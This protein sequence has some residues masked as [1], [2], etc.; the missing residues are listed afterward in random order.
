MSNFLKNLEASGFAKKNNIFS[1]PEIDDLENITHKI[2]S[3]KTIDE[4]IVQSNIINEGVNYYDNTHNTLTFFNTISR[5]FLGVDKKLDILF[6]KLL[7]NEDIK[8]YLIKILGGNYKINTCVLRSGDENSNYLG[9]HTDNNYQFTFSV[10]CNKV[11]SSDYTTLFLP[12]SHKFAYSFKNSIEK[13]NPNFF[14]LFLK[15][16]FGEVGDIVSFFNKT[17]HGVQKNEYQKKKSI[18]MLLAFHKDSD[19]NAK[20]LI[21]PQKTLYK[22]KFENVF[23][24]DVLK[25]FEK[26]E[27]S[28]N[29][30]LDNRENLIDKINKKNSLNI[31]LKFYCYLLRLI[32]LILSI[33]VSTYRLLKN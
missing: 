3:K 20:S 9:L 14:K 24:Y 17:M 8:N 32:K 28:R 29:Y 15:P 13:I 30:L 21:L 23:S 10:F 2:I 5:N 1:R 26:K 31:K 22:E 12:G 27:S 33:L 7:S 16:S 25:L 11:N 18:V 4:K 19:K 6:S